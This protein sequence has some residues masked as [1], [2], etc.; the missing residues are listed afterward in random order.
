MLTPE[1]W[2]DQHPE[3]WDANEATLT[4]IFLTAPELEAW[5]QQA[6]H[7]AVVT[8]ITQIIQECEADRTLQHMVLENPNGT[9][10]HLY[11]ISESPDQDA[12]AAMRALT[13]FNRR[14]DGD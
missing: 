11:K 3:F 5:R 6:L 1:E 4:Q 13:D 8:D 10:A 12:D 7:E 14:K 2:L 9:V